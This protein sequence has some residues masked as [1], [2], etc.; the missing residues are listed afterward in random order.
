[1]PPHAVPSLTQHILVMA[2]MEGGERILLDMDKVLSSDE[3]A[4]L[5]EA[6]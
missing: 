2:K 3:L 4:L 6:P 1:M 5:K